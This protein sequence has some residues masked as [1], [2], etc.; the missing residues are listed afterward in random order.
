MVGGIEM[1]LTIIG[2][3]LDFDNAFQKVTKVNIAYNKYK[4]YAEIDI[5]QYRFS[6][7]YS[8]PLEDI[9]QNPKN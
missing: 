1:L 7:I 6:L 2:E 9:S 4:E 5:N 3:T 8:S